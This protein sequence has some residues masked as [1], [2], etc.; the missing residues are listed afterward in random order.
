MSSDDSSSVNDPLLEKLFAEAEA[1]IEKRGRP[2]SVDASTPKEPVRAKTNVSGLEQTNANHTELPAQQPANAEKLQKLQERLATQKKRHE[3]DL[4]LAL[5]KQRDTLIRQYLE[6]MDDLE[7]AIGMEVPGGTSAQ[8]IDAFVGG[9]RQVFAGGLSTLRQ[10]GVERFD[11]LGEPFDPA[12]HEAMRRE[13]S[14]TFEANHVCEVFQTGYMIGDR[15][16]RAARVSVSSG[17]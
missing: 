10:N 9:I 3:R 12:R 1:C 11:S 5:S 4:E 2:A 6:L 7:R 14:E 16:L 15:L 17:K 8:G 13:S